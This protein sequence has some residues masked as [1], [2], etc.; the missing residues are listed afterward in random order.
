MIDYLHTV[1]GCS[2]QEPVHE[3]RQ[4]GT[5]VEATSSQCP[6]CQSD[7]IVTYSLR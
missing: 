7:E 2:D 6:T 3:C 1:F 5:T 4:C